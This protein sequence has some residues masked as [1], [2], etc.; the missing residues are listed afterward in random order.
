MI[1]AMILQSGHFEYFKKSHGSILNVMPEQHID[2][3]VTFTLNKKP[4][5]ILAAW[6]KGEAVILGLSL[7]KLAKKY[8][9]SLQRFSKKILKGIFM[10]GI[11]E[12]HAHA[13]NEI[14]HHWLKSLGFTLTTEKDHT[15]FEVYKKWK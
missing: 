10:T 1:E 7:S 12:V 15:G 11:K 8:P 9:L 14:S 3:G 2:K 6:Q 13:D 5:A 4:I